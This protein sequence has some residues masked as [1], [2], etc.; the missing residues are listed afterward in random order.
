MESP[1]R[2]ILVI[3]GKGGCGKTTIATNLAVA[4][5]CRN[6]NVALMD[7]DPQASSSHWATQRDDTLPKVELIAK[8]ERP[9][10]YQTTSF[11]HRLPTNTQVVVIDG[12]SNARGRDLESLLRQ[13]D[14]ILVPMLPSAIDIRAGGKFIADLLTHRIY[15]SAPRPVGVI[16]NRIQPNTQT[17]EKLMHFLGCLDVPA[18]AE[19]R[20]SPVYIDAAELGQGVVDMK[21]CR[22]ARKETA[23]WKRLLNWIDAQVPA[24]RT[25]VA[26]IRM[27]PRAAGL[28]KTDT[29]ASHSA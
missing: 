29:T 24:R 18:V 1:A 6:I 25:T 15:R 8:H 20:D 3:N 19:F 26:S 11:H 17:H 28:K 10:M 5:A 22:A 23:Q 4:Y 27:K 13:T 9:N 2:R 21:D 14:I 12:H 7:N 16:A